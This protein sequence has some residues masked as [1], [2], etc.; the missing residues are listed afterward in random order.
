PEQIVS[1][2]YAKPPCDLYS[3]GV[4]LYQYLTDKLPFNAATGRKALRA[5]LEDPPIPLRD[6]CPE[7]PEGLA[8]AVERALAKDPADRFASAEEMHDA[9]DPYSQREP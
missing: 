6:V 8:R 7:I 4:T 9:L 2:R 5:I 3:L 1:S